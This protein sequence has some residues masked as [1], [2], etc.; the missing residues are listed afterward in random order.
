M[1]FPGGVSIDS[2]WH[3][4]DEHKSHAKKQIIDNFV[5]K[6]HFRILFFLNE[7]IA[8]GFTFCYERSFFKYFDP[9]NLNC[10]L[11]KIIILKII[12][13]ASLPSSTRASFRGGPLGVSDTSGLF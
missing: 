9:Q 2:F 4:Q 7:A 5:R 6:N 1:A 3:L 11:K 13:L 12:G 10:N 8:V